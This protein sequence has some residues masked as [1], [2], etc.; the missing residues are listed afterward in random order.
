MSLVYADLMQGDIDIARVAS[1]LADP[2]RAKILLALADGRAL[3]AS[4]LSDEASV[5]P[6]TAS[7]HLGR[8]LNGG[9]LS[10]E[11][12]GRHRYYRLAG[13]HVGELLEG[14]AKVAPSAPVKSLKEG[15]RAQAVRFARTCYDHLAGR[16]GTELMTSM[17]ARGLLD[18]GDGTFDPASAERDRLS[19]PGFDI[20]YRLTEPGSDELAELGIDIRRLP[21]RRRLVRYC[22]DWSEQRHHLAGALGAAIAERLFEL[23]WIKH[24]KATRAVRITEPGFEGLRGTFGVELRG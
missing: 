24:G 10:V 15:S 9:L 13:P 4:V 16:L 7:E 2:A 23:G 1:L 11:A 18:G 14:L 5:A 20:D 22:V 21:T 8:L 6:S 19:S 3:A 12:H 17:L